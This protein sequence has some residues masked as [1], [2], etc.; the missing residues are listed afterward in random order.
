I[1]RK[2]IEVIARSGE[3]LFIFMYILVVAGFILIVTSGLIDVTN[4][5]PAL[6]EG[7]LPPLKV[8][9]SET[10]YFPFTEAI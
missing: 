3:L 2:G 5:K 4:L 9:L 1:I 6:E 7:L 8:A 10:L